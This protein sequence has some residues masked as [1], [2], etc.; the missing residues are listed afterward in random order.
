[1]QQFIIKR[2][3]IIAPV[4]N[5]FGP[6]AVLNPRYLLKTKKDEGRTRFTAEASRVLLASYSNLAKPRVPGSPVTP[7]GAGAINLGRIV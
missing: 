4:E 1:M 7:L 3:N 5:A 2:I 6:R